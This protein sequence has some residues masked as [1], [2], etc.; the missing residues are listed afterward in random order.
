MLAGRYAVSAGVRPAAAETARDWSLGHGYFFP[1]L[2]SEPVPLQMSSRPKNE[3]KIAMAMIRAIAS[4]TKKCVNLAGFSVSAAIACAN[5]LAE[6]LIYFSAEKGVGV[7][8]WLLMLATM[9]P[10]RS[11][12]SRTLCQAGSFWN[13]VHL[14]SRSASDSHGSM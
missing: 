5:V 6:A 14:V 2:L 1:G 9:G 11:L 3:T 12:S 8:I 4:Y 7:R 10:S 13:A